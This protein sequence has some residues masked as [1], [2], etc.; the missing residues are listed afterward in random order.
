MSEVARFDSCDCTH[1]PLESVVQASI[2]IITTAAGKLQDDTKDNSLEPGVSLWL[3]YAFIS[4]V[5]SG[6]LLLVS[7][8]K[9]DLLP[10]AR[11]SQINP[12][13]VP[14]E[15]D[16][17]AE[18]AGITVSKE[19]LDEGM[20]ENTEKEKRLKAPEP[21]FLWARWASLVAGAII[22]VIGWVIFGLGVSWG[23]H[24]SVI[25]GTVGE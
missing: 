9:P 18:R 24:G 23:V 12:Q 1:G 19:N 5:I 17:L 10:A 22:I 3:A 25:A 2:V 6:G 21:P 11:L 13:S 4:V 7:Y 8:L 14:A 16:R 20:T 15:V